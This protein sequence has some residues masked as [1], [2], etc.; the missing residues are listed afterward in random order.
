MKEIPF[1]KNNP[2]ILISRTDGIG[3]LIL[4][5]PLASLIKKKYPKA[6]IFFL[7]Q[8][9]TKDIVSLMGK[10][11]TPLIYDPVKKHQG[12][13]G[14]FALARELKEYDLDAV[15]VVRPRLTVVLS[16][17]I[18]SIGIRIGTSR[19]VYSFLF[20]H[21]IK[22]K[23]KTGGRHETE[24]NAELLRP[25]GIEYEEIH[26]DTEIPVAVAKKISQQLQN[27]DIKKKFIVI[28]PGSK[29]SAL[30][31][32][33]PY[34]AELA[35]LI[36]SRLKLPVILTGSQVERGLLTDLMAQV[37]SRT[38]SLSQKEAP[39][40]KVHDWTLLELAALYK[41]SALLIA[42]STGPLH[43]ASLLGTHT[44]STFPKSRQMR[45]YKWRPIGAGSNITVEPALPDCTRCI[46]HKCP[47]FNCLEKIT[48]QYIFHIVE[49]IL[50]NKEKAG[51]TSRVASLIPEKE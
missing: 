12:I 28:H 17:F 3:D 43:L 21:R 49:N 6:N 48:P 4:T 29:G 24:N 23:R 30:T 51:W 34:V 42:N 16:F 15:I 39:F 26:P 19:R 22:I 10:E 35:F 8:E 27:W 32:P 25:L 33:L 46:D 20:N 50:K 9:Y 45:P 41:K 5:L 13:S 1:T 2:R 47:Y 36:L 31:W 7:V 11:Y 44:I 14:I 18:S 37:K 40:I 38:K